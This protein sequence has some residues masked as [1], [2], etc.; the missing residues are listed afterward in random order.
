MES[1]VYGDTSS[2]EEPINEMK[3]GI[4]RI[5]ELIDNLIDLSRAETGRI[6]VKSEL[7]YFENLYSIIESYRNLAKEKGLEFNF[8]FI[9][10]SPFSSD[11]N[12]LVTI[13]SNLLSNAVKY[14]EKGEIKEK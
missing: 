10:N 7:V 13:I 9:G 1:G 2:L 4:L 12:I 11:Y 3:K 5:G 6:F 14:T 8:D